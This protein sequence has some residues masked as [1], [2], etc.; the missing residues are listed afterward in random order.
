MTADLA[1]LAR[2]EMAGLADEA[3]ELAEWDRRLESAYEHWEIS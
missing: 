1:E 3:G 2:Y